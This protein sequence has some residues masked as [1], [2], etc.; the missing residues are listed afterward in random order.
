MKLA[1]MRFAPIFLAS[2]RKAR[3]LLLV[4][5]L[6]AC[7]STT[8]TPQQSAP[9]FD[10]Q[11]ASIDELLRAANNTAGVESAELRVLALEA[12]IEEGNLDRA[13]RQWAL[14]N[15]LGNYP[16]H[17]Q[18]R[19]SLL[20]ARLALSANRI[21]D[22]LAILSSTDTAG[23]ESRPELLQDYLLL[24]GRAYQE[25]EQY[26]EALSAYLQLGN[27]NQ[28][29]PRANLSIHNEIW[30]AINGFSSAQL[31]NFANTADSYQSRGWVELARVVT[32]EAYSIRSQLDAIAQW[33]RI[34]SQ[35][36][37]A[38]QLPLQLEKLAQT[39]A[40]RP[41]HIA[42]ILPLQDSA[43]RAI[44]EGFLSAYYAALDVSRDV[45][46]ISVFD[47]SNQTII[48][49]IFDAAVASGADLII[50]PLY[51]QLVN[52]LQQLDDLPVPTLALNYADE[53]NSISTNLTQFGLAPEDEI[54]QAVNLA[55]QAGHRNAAI[56]T[57]QS[58][59]YQRLQQAFANSWVA[60][61]G[62]LV[63]QSTFS[64]DNDY[65]DVIK[66][67]MAIDSSELR[68][69]RL[70]QLLPRSN[71]EFT[72][73]RRGDIDFIFLIAN[74]RE[75]RQIKPTLAFYFAGDIPVYAL[76]SIYDGLDNQSANQDLNG[77]VFT[78]APWILANY[79]PLKSNAA[80]SLRPAQGPVQRFR[81]MGID[82][83]RLYSRLQQFDEEDI[84]SLRGATGILSMD[85]NGRI[86][87]RL[88]V[89]RFVDGK[90]TLQE[91]PDAASD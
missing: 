11:A 61:G 39:W 25:N 51:K 14:L 2:V 89:A 86:H 6:Q 47:S 15:D 56:I 71:V 78:D 69:D 27:A 21:A 40:Q 33:R 42:L 4:I 84:T 83:F 16:E 23:L 63:S 19:A 43:G 76:P 53:N 5:L 58:S 80:S 77:I 88:E 29:K 7:G 10:P 68:R 32:S 24:L 35:H 64:G 55:W 3:L 46:K 31:N 59:D 8:N 72:P 28:N 79:D 20:D 66:R 48:Y 30:N 37:A 54:E 70:V 73:R 22:A 60:R 18:L 26:G 82:S 91:S 13:A 49:P 67:L 41:K 1:S 45:P 81:A 57:P 12:L 50:G 52:Q 34:W 65:A 74:P 17:L 44:Q 38:Q 62:N 90:A 75:G 36:P 9:D 85:S 87:R